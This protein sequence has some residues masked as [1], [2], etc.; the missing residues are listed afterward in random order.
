M[1]QKFISK[2]KEIIIKAGKMSVD[3]RDKGL[4]VQKKGDDSPV[5]NADLEISNFIYKNLTKLDSNIP[6]ICEE[7][8]L[9]DVSNAEMFWLV[10]PIDGTRSYIRN[11]DSFT[12]NIALIRN[13]IP[14][15]GLIYQPTL[16]KLYFTDH[17]GNFFAEQYGKNM[18]AIKRED[19]SFIAVVSSRNFNDTTEQYI[20][21]NNFSEILAVPSSIKLCMIAEGSGDVYPKFGPTME[22]DIAAGH[23]LI[24]AS[25]GK[26][27]DNNTDE[28]LL[29]GKSGFKNS[30]FIAFNKKH[31]K[32]R[33]Q[34]ER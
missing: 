12:V 31:L 25:G 10:D 30:D 2:L 34:P 14:I 29:Y 23:A 33:L 28:T 5:T 32:A 9:L 16:Q 20:R 6:I 11:I 8:P 1:D 21:E 27:L 3:L 22:W 7:Q 18:Q 13:Q 24:N 19:D 15:I 4:V 26:V 17:E